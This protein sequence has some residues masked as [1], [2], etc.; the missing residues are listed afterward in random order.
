MSP[1]FF[2]VFYLSRDV[3]FSLCWHDSLVEG[4]TPFQT[5]SLSFRLASIEK[6]R[7][8]GS[9]GDLIIRVAS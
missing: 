4:P 6:T 7:I 3:R 2:V 1:D 8:K 9:K 5:Y